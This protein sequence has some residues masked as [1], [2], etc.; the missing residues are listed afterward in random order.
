[1]SKS[2]RAALDYPALRRKLT[3][4]RARGMP[5]FLE[6][7]GRRLLDAWL[8]TSASEARPLPRTLARL[9]SGDAAREIGEITGA[10]I[11]AEQPEVLTNAA[12]AAGCAFCCI[13]LEGD[14]GLI[15]EAEATALHGALAPFAGQPDGR[16]WH[17]HACA[18][19]D[20]ETRQCR[21]YEA[22]PT[23]C[24]SFLSVDAE[25]CRENAEGGDE[26]GSGMLGNHLDYLTVLA[27]SREVMRGTALLHTYS[28]EALAQAA[29]DGAPLDAA[30]K[31]ARHPTSELEETCED[32]GNS[33]S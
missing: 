16:A 14:G 3:K 24:R 33:P 5:D 19:L 25:A 9:A 32:I 1:M 22:R 27:L 31:A 18:A 20:P 4:A 2:A 6:D 8:A 15:G 21:A 13:L 12:C 23:V 17:A 30:L 26:D 28:L 7:R 29:C 10:Q 11:R